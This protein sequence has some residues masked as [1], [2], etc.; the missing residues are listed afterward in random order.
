MSEEAN[1]VGRSTVKATYN[2]PT[3]TKTLE[4]SLPSPRPTDIKSKIA[5]LGEVR[6]ATKQLQDDINTFLTAKMEE[7]KANAS[8][9]ATNKPKSRDEEEEENYGEEKIEED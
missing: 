4:K 3:D 1:G 7:D 6:S 5:Y 9:T 2:S 8:A